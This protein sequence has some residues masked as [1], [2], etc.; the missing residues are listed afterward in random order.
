MRKRRE[1]LRRVEP[2]GERSLE[3]GYG[4]AYKA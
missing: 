2:F 4:G 3:I 1:M